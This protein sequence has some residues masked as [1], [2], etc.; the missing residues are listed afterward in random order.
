MELGFLL[1]YVALLLYAYVIGFGLFGKLHPLDPR[2]RSEIFRR[3][4]SIIL[5]GLRALVTVYAPSFIALSVCH[6]Y[7]IPIDDLNEY[8]TIGYTLM[9]GWVSATAMIAYR[10]VLRSDAK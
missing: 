1:I 4:D 9:F 8:V 6:A 10:K 7:R 2:A 5:R 3:L